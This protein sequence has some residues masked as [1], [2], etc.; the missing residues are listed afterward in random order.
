M[1]KLVYIVVNLFKRL[2]PHPKPMKNLFKILI[3]SLLVFSCDEGDG[4]VSPS[5]EVDVD[6]GLIRVPEFEGFPS[7]GNQE[8][9]TLGVGYYFFYKDSTLEF[10]DYNSEGFPPGM[11]FYFLFQDSPY[12]SFTYEGVDFS[13]DISDID[14]NPENGYF[15]FMQLT[16]TRI[17]YNK[18]MNYFTLFSDGFWGGSNSYSS[19][20]PNEL[21]DYR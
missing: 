8:L 11:S 1:M 12:L 15:N 3:L 19:A 13:F 5:N 2:T 20:S 14:Y 6:W 16:P 10:P 4:G 21:I 9:D 7:I 18:E 17:I